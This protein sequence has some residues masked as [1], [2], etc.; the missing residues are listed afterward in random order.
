MPSFPV[1]V[2]FLH[3]S[4]A[5]AELAVRVNLEAHSLEPVQSFQLLAG[6]VFFFGEIKL[7]GKKIHLAAGHHLGIQLPKGPG[8]GV[9]GIGERLL[10]L[11]PSLLVDGG[12]HVLREK[13]LTTNLSPGR[14]FRTSQPEGDGA[15]GADT[16]SDLL[17]LLTIAAGGPLHKQA[18]L[19][20]KS[21]CKPIHLQFTGIGQGLI[22]GD[23][24]GTGLSEFVSQRF[25][26]FLKLAPQRFLPFKPTSM[27]R[28]GCKNIIQAQQRN[29]V[30]HTGFPSEDRLT[31]PLGGAIGPHQMGMTLLQL[32][33]LPIEAV[34]LLIREDRFRQNVIG[35]TGFIELLPQSVCPGLGL[36]KG[37]GRQ[38]Q[39]GG[40]LV[41]TLR[42][43]SMRQSSPTLTKVKSRGSTCFLS[44]ELSFTV[45]MI[46][47]S[48]MR[49]RPDLRLR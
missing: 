5:G 1:P 40:S 22:R 6:L 47:P 30:G 29:S 39:D 37:R 46:R 42:M 49:G 7:I 12:E 15:N 11:I 38:V 26:P 19:I 43:R 31:H 8:T 45:R 20:A 44:S 25:L 27:V 48:W 34:V 28:T 13:S 36:S 18:L 14:W 33:Q 2:K 3:V 24:G 41:Q 23:V 21:Q 9:A 4:Q 32:H 35:V 17:T 10:P 16:G